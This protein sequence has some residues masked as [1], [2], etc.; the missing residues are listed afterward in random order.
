MMLVTPEDTEQFFEEYFTKIKIHI[1]E[2]IKYD[3]EN[4]YDRNDD[5]ADTV[6]FEGQ[7]MKEK[8]RRGKS[9]ENVKVAS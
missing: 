8:Y 3:D 7:E 1:R 2:Q 4:F 5:I 6:S 9:A